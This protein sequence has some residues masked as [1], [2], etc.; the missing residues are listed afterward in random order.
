MGDMSNGDER[1]VIV[2]GPMSRPFNSVSLAIA[3][4]RSAGRMPALRPTPT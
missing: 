4:T 1:S 3:P 2:I